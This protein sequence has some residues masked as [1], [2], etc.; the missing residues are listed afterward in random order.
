MSDARPGEEYLGDDPAKAGG[1]ARLV[2]IGRLETPWQARDET[3][4]NLRQ[5]RA[6]G[7]PAR[8]VVAEP[9]RRGLHRLERYRHIVLLTWFDRSRRDLIVQRPRHSKESRGTFSLRSPVRPNPIGLAV[10]DLISIDGNILTIRHIDCF[11]GTPLIDIKPYFASTD[12]K[13][14]A[15]VGW[16]KKELTPQ[17]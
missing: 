6:A 1:D 7:R 11:D 9:Y 8:L 5:A 13:P 12:S 15:E 14:E 10:A 3:P 4:R 16:R 2:F 17:S